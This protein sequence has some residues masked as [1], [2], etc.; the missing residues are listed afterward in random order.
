MTA[1]VPSFDLQAANLSEPDNNVPV[2]RELVPFGAVVVN[3][4]RA[5]IESNFGTSHAPRGDVVNISESYFGNG[6]RDT[7]PEAARIVEDVVPQHDIGFVRHL[8]GE[9]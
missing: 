3:L 6:P 4:G 8:I 2:K 1:G 9:V 5:I 7:G